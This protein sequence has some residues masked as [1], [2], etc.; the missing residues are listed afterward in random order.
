MMGRLLIGIGKLDHVAIVERTA[1]K[2]DPGGQIVTGK[3]KMATFL[4]LC[5]P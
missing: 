5:N 4:P 1:E 3:A 2:D